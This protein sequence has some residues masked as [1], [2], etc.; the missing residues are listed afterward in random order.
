MLATRV[1]TSKKKNHWLLYK[2]F[3]D[4][5]DNLYGINHSSLW[6]R[7]NMRWVKAI[8]SFLL[9]DMA[10]QELMVSAILNL[11]IRDCDCNTPLHVAILMEDLPVIKL[12]MICGASLFIKNNDGE[13]P[14]QLAFERVLVKNLFHNDSNINEKV[15]IQKFN[16]NICKLS[17]VQEIE[18]QIGPV[19]TYTTLPNIDGPVST[20][21][22]MCIEKILHSVI[23]R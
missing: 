6:F 20:L 11:S 9:C 4:I 8:L 2:E 17:E 18:S 14:Y 16:Y 19:A 10:S 3:G 5:C 15:R 12:L 22:E 21:K 13:T 1:L 23:K 7:F